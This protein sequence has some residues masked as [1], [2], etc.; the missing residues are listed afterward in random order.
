[1]SVNVASQSPQ[2]TPRPA[3]VSLPPAGG[4][5]KTQQ[6]QPQDQSRK[7]AREERLLQFAEEERIEDE[8]AVRTLLSHVVTLPF[9]TAIEYHDLDGLL[10]MA[11]PPAH[12]VRLERDETVQAP[13]SPPRSPFVSQNVPPLAHDAATVR[14]HISRRY[15]PLGTFAVP[16]SPRLSGQRPGPRR[17]VS[18]R[19]TYR[20]SPNLSSV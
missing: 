14:G 5:P 7:K 19:S 17:R 13:M 8:R 6:Q 4:A 10:H 15:H 2:A 16:K 18:E 1:M 11:A 3:L 9:D 20:S 12:F